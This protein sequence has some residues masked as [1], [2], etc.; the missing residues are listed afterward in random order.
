MMILMIFIFI[1]RKTPICGIASENDSLIKMT[2]F[3]VEL[4]YKT[5]A[6]ST[7]ATR[8]TENI[9]NLAINAAG[10]VVIGSNNSIGVGLSRDLDMEKSTLKVH[11]PDGS[12]NVVRFGD[13][14][15]IKVSAV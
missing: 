15:D 12:F 13:A 3:D 14:T 8:P 5:G 1:F 7:S 11:L 10:N 4:P 2:D 9:N 6:V